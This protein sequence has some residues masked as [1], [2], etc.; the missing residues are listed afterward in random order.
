[1]KSENK[2]GKGERVSFIFLQIIF[3]GFKHLN[4]GREFILKPDKILLKI[5][6]RILNPNLKTSI[7]NLCQY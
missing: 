2:K 1:M 6:K 3:H 4:V 5:C 7:G